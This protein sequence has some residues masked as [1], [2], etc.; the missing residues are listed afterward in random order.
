MKTKFTSLLALLLFSTAAQASWVQSNMALACA[1]LAIYEEEDGSTRIV[2]DCIKSVENKAFTAEERTACFEKSADAIADM[3]DGDGG[4][5]LIKCFSKS[6]KATVMVDATFAKAKF[7]EAEKAGKD[8]NLGKAKDLA[9][10]AVNNI[11]DQL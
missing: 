3:D 8:W 1:K 7:K 2:K 10:E 9:K 5:T 6:G 11:K 4:A